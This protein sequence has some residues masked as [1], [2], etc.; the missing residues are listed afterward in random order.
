MNCEALCT[1]YISKYIK[2]TAEDSRECAKE[3]MII[4]LFD[5]YIIV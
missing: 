2:I 5:I 4:Y 3:S 1:I